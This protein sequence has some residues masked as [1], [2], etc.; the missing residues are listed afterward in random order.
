MPFI[1]KINILKIIPEQSSNAFFDDNSILVSGSDNT[2][3]INAHGF[4]C[5]GYGTIFNQSKLTLSLNLSLEANFPE[6]LIRGYLIQGISFFDQLDGVFSFCLIDILSKKLLGIRDH[7]GLKNLF[8]QSTPEGFIISD[9]IKS[10]IN[11][12]PPQINHSAI[13]SYFDFEYNN[14]LYNSK[15]I[16]EGIHRVLPAH[17]LTYISGEITQQLYWIPSIDKYKNLSSSQQVNIFK[18]KL[19][20]SVEKRI[21]QKESLCTNLSGGLDSSSI[22]SISKMINNHI[23]AIYFS[24]G[25]SS[26]DERFYAKK[27]VDKW[28]LNYYEVLPQKSVLGVAKKVIEL[29]G[30]PDMLFMPSSSFFSIGEKAQILN[31]K[32]IL[33]GDGGDSIVANGNEYLYQLYKHKKWDLLKSSIEKHVTHKDLTHYFKD[34]KK[35]SQKTKWKLYLNFFH[36]NIIVKLLGQHQ[37]RAA[38]EAFI[39]ANKYFGYS[40]SSLIKRLVDWSLAKLSKE[41]INDNLVRNELVRKVRSEKNFIF[42]LHSLPSTFT[43][44]QKEHLGYS[45]TNLNIAVIEQQNAIMASFGV[46]AVHPFLDKDLME[47]AIAVSPELR[48]DNGLGR[49]SLRH[50]MLGILPE[51]VRLRTNKVEFSEYLFSYFEDLWSEAKGLI[52][53]SHQV[54]RYVNKSVFDKLIIYI[55]DKSISSQKKSKYIWLVNRTIYF[56]L[57]LDFIENIKSS[58]VYSN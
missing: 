9:N 14:S 24:T 51:E 33:T 23:N 20:K 48:F 19:I 44:F 16:Y 36:T 32:K 4:I 41:M 21:S 35:K 49:G 28:D 15:T 10:I 12:L 45:F 6:F 57:W 55:F 5:V 11:L 31:C 34:W 22:S 58:E 27:V 38:L 40:N 30:M 1:C 52:E 3:F 13:V 37:F 46:E 47:I 26:T 25:H 53:P 43:A 39:N 50:A 42:N 17:L 54:W 8:Y 7:F 29:C 56:A 18:D 2:F